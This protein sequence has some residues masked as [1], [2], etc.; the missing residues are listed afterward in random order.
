MVEIFSGSHFSTKNGIKGGNL[1]G[2]DRAPHGRR[3]QVDFAPSDR[4]DGAVH[5]IPFRR[6][7]WWVGLCFGA[8]TSVPWR[9]Q[10]KEPPLNKN[11]EPP[12]N[13]IKFWWRG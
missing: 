8:R 1:P 9:T 12:L 4:V 3:E 11:K 5:S 13:K 7:G 10:N 6:R 2:S